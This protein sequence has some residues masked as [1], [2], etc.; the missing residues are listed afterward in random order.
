MRSFLRP[1][2]LLVILGPAVAHATWSCPE[3]E[4]N[5]IVVQQCYSPTG[6][7]DTSCQIGQTIAIDDAAAYVQ[8]TWPAG[9]QCSSG[10]VGSVGQ[11]I[12]NGT[13][14]GFQVAC[15]DTTGAATGTV[16]AII[17]SKTC[18]AAAVCTVQVHEFF[19][20]A[21]WSVVSSGGGDTFCVNHC[22]TELRNFGLFVGPPGATGGGIPG[23]EVTGTVCELGTPAPPVAVTDHHCE[24]INGQT[25][26]TSTGERQV[27][28]N[29][30]AVQ[31]GAVYSGHTTACI[32]SSGE[33][34]AYSAPEQI[35]Q[36]SDG[37]QVASPATLSPPGPDNGTPGQAATPDLVLSIPGE[38]TSYAYWSPSTVA[39]SST[40]SGSTGGGDD[41]GGDDGT[42]NCGTSSKPCKVTVTGDFAGPELD[43]GVPAIGD[44]LST[45]YNEVSGA[46]IVAALSSIASAV[47]TGGTKPIAHFTLAPISGDTVYTVE[48]PDELLDSVRPVLVAVM[49]MGFALGAIFLF[50]KA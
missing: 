20:L 32:V 50:F 23:F 13:Q 44:R 8:G 1:V 37:A 30:D 47:P 9:T 7:P 48:L 6:V 22:K 43:P 31:A 38:D 42:T 3:G 28:V 12:D 45:F 49:R 39:S 41:N 46:P 26:C 4:G 15:V 14:A 40:Y 24:A 11:L 19:A 34:V 25:V 36:T 21:N 27:A 16:A 33:C 10:K 18:S 5:A 2:A 29:G 35:A 17:G